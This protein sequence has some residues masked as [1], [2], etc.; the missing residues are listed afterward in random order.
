M[1]FKPTDKIKETNSRQSYT[2]P[3]IVLLVQRQESIIF[4]TNVTEKTLVIFLEKINYFLK[5][6]IRTKYDA[7]NY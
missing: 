3:L 2:K 6:I 7:L 5:K 1:Y 4:Y